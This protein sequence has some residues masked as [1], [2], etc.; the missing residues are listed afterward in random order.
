VS[1]PLRQPVTAALFLGGAVVGVVGVG[2]V[3]SQRWGLGLP[4]AILGLTLELSGAALHDRQH[5]RH[6][7]HPHAYGGSR[8]ATVPSGS[9][10]RGDRTPA[11]LRQPSSPRP[12][13]P[14]LNHPVGSGVPQRVQRRGRPCAIGDVAAALARSVT[15]AATAAPA[16]GDSGRAS[17]LLARSRQAALLARFLPGARLRPPTTRVTGR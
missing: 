3:V 12:A 8:I 2:L 1:N 11:A 13:P 17:P 4:V 16:I 15:S 9:R 14:Q 6:G 5:R 10:R 7:E